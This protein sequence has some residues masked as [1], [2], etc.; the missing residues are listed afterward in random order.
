VFIYIGDLAS[1]FAGA[2]RALR[3]DGLFAFSTEVSEGA[4]SRLL[5][6][7]RYSHSAAYL[8]RLAAEA[9]WR[10]ESA[11][12]QVLREEDRQGVSGHLMVLRRV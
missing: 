6:S 4:E 9:G 2:Q 12:R 11:T 1:V 5:E 10:I 8:Q 3:P 7:L